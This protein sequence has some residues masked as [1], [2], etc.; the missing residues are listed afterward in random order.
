M[1][2]L[3]VAGLALLWLIWG[4]TNAAE[5]P[6]NGQP[7]PAEGDRS[8]DRIELRLS[9][10]RD[11]DAIPAQIFDDLL[12]LRRNF[13]D[14]STRLDPKLVEAQTRREALG[15]VIAG[16]DKATTD[17]RRALDSEIPTLQKQQAACR[18]VNLRAD[19]LYARAVAYREARV[20]AVLL[21]RGEPITRIFASDWGSA[22]Q[23]R[24]AAAS[25][26]SDSSSFMRLDKLERAVFISIVGLAFAF[27]FGLRRTLSAAMP[28]RADPPD[29]L[30]DALRAIGCSAI[31]ELPWILLAIG[32]LA[33]WFVVGVPDQPW[34]TLFVLGLALAV[35]APT[36]VIIHGLLAPPPPAVHFLPVPDTVAVQ[37]ARRLHL[38]AFVL[39]GGAVFFAS[40]IGSSLPSGAL[41]LARAAFTV[42]VVVNLA[43]VLWLVGDLPIWRSALLRVVL[44]LAL[45][46]A[47]VADLAGYH[48]LGFYVVGGISITLAGYATV[49]LI[50]RL[51]EDG[52]DAFD[53]G[54]YRW[55]RSARERLGVKPGETTP[56][57]SWL[58]FLTQIVLWGGY[59]LLLLR[60][61]G[62]SDL[63]FER[64]LSWVADGFTLGDITVHPVRILGA[65]LLF[66][67]LLTLTGW[68][69][70]RMDQRW[71]KKT[72]LDRG[73]REATALSAG[74]LGAGV[75]A[76]IALSVA[77]VSFTNVA[78]IAGALSV[79]IGFGLQN[80]VNNFVSGLIL[81][82][83]RPIRTGDWIV[84]GSTEG[85]VKKIA[86]RSTQIQTFDRADV[87][88]PNSE[89]ISGQ[90]TNWMLRDSMG[91]VRAPVGVAY[92]SDTQLVKQTLLEVGR[93]HP[94]VITDG[95]VPE[96]TVIFV[97]FGDSTLD[98]EL[99]CFIRNVDRR[100]AVLSDLNFAID[101]AFRKA[102][103]EIAFPQRDLHLR[104]WPNMQMPGAADE[105]VTPT[106]K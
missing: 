67:A 72:R 17:L 54:R 96:P 25:L 42:V 50:S 2:T 13:A 41:L 43:W 39:L 60:A 91:R 19:D 3:R 103:I 102:G 24:D 37:L 78:L 18:A 104:S 97:R 92:G 99:R 71:L 74:Y 80:I 5:P 48:N 79:G 1:N 30:T 58:R 6:A 23:W 53:E 45:F 85:Y 31:R 28:A 73:A 22:R 64:T 36:R 52:F 51:A 75:A 27:G 68:V 106:E 8:L 11:D 66:A 46:A 7:V 98:F 87:I 9:R 10:L 12:S 88:V 84:V 94:E 61:W 35:F 70:R 59:L 34:P 14:C 32:I 26:L 93:V 69:K 44:V 100:L 101:A 90:V 49:W 55:Q 20:R 62:F 21:E 105:L 76:L 95:R 81:L 83:E 47:L 16:E 82:I 89:L 56:G 4:V 63:A 86:I 33:F 40:A 77:G 29:L 57:L 15:D 65:L 38:L